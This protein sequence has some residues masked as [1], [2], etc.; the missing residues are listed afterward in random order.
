M[1]LRMFHTSMDNKLVP[2]VTAEFDL[3]AYYM[4]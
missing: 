4:W 1:L 2:A 3:W